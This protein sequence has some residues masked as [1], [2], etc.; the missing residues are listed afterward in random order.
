LFVVS[1]LRSE[2][3]ALAG[4]VPGA[5]LARCGMGPS[6]VTTWLP[7]LL[8]ADPGVIVVAGV[9]GALDPSLRPGDVI[10]A[11]EV[12]DAHGRAVLRAGGP[13]PVRWPRT[14]NRPPSPVP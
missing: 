8:Q 10:V 7:E 6:R 11:N 9:A 12:R 2:F 3:A 1:A 5:R 13:R 4:Q 14:W